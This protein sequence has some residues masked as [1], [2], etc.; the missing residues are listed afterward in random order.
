MPNRGRNALRIVNPGKKMPAQGGQGKSC[1]RWKTDR[2][3]RRSCYAVPGGPHLTCL[4][5]QG[6]PTSAMNKKKARRAT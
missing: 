4:K 5:W 6:G 2:G 3:N 1:T